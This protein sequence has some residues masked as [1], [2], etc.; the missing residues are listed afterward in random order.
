MTLN[1]TV[2]H[3]SVVTQVSDRRMVDM[4]T[5]KLID[6][7]ANKAVVLACKD[8]VLSITF[9]G[10]GR[11]PTKRVDEWLGEE[12]LEA[13]IPELNADDAVKQIATSATSWFRSFPKDWD[14]RQ[15]FMIAGWQQAPAGG[16]EQV[17]WIVANN[18]NGAWMT[19]KA[20]EEFRIE[21]FRGRKHTASILVTGCA[22]AFSRPHRRRLLA[23]IRNSKKGSDVSASID[24]LERSIVSAIRECAD[25]LN[26]GG[27]IGKNCMAISL[28]SSRQGRAI[29]YAESGSEHAYGP[30]VVWNAGGPNAMVMDTDVS[31][32]RGLRGVAF[33]AENNGFILNVDRPP[34]QRDP[35][36]DVGSSNFVVEG[37]VKLCE[38]K[39]GTPMQNQFELMRVI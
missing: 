9:T 34:G 29:H 14:R 26:A 8:S 33:G 27:V 11:T 6:D 19:N 28:L 21:P 4:R 25:N 15:A 18:V 39:H 35:A 1:I 13:G 24:A 30:I 16:M 12:L 17:A 32:G 38:P 10:I 7:E 23:G 37:K 36:Q 20:E 2:V 5:R 31:P 22:P 3:P